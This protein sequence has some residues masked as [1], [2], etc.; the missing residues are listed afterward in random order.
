MNSSD[1]VDSN[2]KNL[3]FFAG[4]SQNHLKISRRGQKQMEPKKKTQ[5]IIQ[6]FRLFKDREMLKLQNFKPEE[7]VMLRF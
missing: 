5:I 6:S 3:P 1:L 2:R 4:V 7:A